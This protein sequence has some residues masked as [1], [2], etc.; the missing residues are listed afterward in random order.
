MPTGSLFERRFLLD[1]FWFGRTVLSHQ[2]R[3]LHEAHERESDA[4]L[5]R[6]YLVAVHTLIMQEYEHVAAWILALRRRADSGTPLLD[7]LLQYHPGEGTLANALK[8]LS[9]G[10]Q[11]LVHCGIDTSRFVPHPL[12]PREASSR[13]ADVWR[14]LEYHAQ[15]QTDRM[16]LYNKSK[17]G[18]VF[19]SS[20][21]AINPEVEDS[22]PVAVYLKKTEAG[23]L[24]PAVIGLRS[25]KGQTQAMASQLLGLAGALS[26]LLFFYALQEH[27]GI[28]GEIRPLLDD[29]ERM[30]ALPE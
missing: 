8:G 16:P 2:A 7:T 14:G 17:H 5:R 21:T 23:L 9:D 18:M 26:D 4:D 1:Y 30:V 3:A 20:A 28:W 12:P 10:E 13:I 6:A 11:L 15:Q 22:G 25:A 19:V 27:E 24:E 29:K